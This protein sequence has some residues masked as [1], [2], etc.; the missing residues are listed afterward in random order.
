MESETSQKLFLEEP[1]PVTGFQCAV[2]KV[3]GNA[4]AENTFVPLQASGGTDFGLPKNFW[5]LLSTDPGLLSEF[6]QLIESKVSE[7]VEE[8][9][10][11]IAEEVAAAAKQDGLKQGL[12]EAKTLLETEKKRI[13]SF[14]EELLKQ[15]VAVLRE[16]E[17]M[18]SEAFAHLLRRFLVP[19][20]AEKSELLQKWLSESVERFSSTKKVRVY[21]SP[22]DLGLLQQN[23]PMRLEERWEYLADPNLKPGEIHCECD[24]GGIFFSPDDQMESLEKL[25]TQ[26]KRSTEVSES[27]EA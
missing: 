1:D 20:A 9:S 15:K 7:R 27:K 23:S 26:F 22:V 8:K 14:C 16:H 19:N 6:N 3:E 21:F 4:K 18:W 5:N 10:R 11:K 17:A 13:D 12:E 2:P 24:A 25:I